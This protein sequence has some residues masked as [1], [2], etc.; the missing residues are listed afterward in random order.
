MTQ[1]ICGGLFVVVV[2]ITFLVLFGW[3]VLKGDLIF[4]GGRIHGRVARVIGVI[5]LLGIIAGAYLAISVL[6]LGIQPTFAPLAS[7]LLGFFVVVIVA[8]RFLSVFFWHSN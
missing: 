1:S 4:H 8:V 7:L 2:F 5:G 6:V 3:A